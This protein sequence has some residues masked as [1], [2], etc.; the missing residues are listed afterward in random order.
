MSR[1]HNKFTKSILLNEMNYWSQ[2]VKDAS[3]DLGKMRHEKVIF[4][5]DF[6]FLFPYVWNQAPSPGVP[7]WYPTGRKTMENIIDLEGILQKTPNFDI[8]F[9][10]PSFLELLDSIRHQKNEITGFRFNNDLEKQFQ[11]V[12]QETSEDI[13]MDQLKKVLVSKGLPPRLLNF[14]WRTKTMD[15]DLD[16]AFDRIKSVFS[17]HKVLNGIGD[18]VNI[19]EIER[20][21][22]QFKEDY[23]KLFEVMYQSRGSHDTRDEPDKKLHYGVDVSNILTT[24]FLDKHVEGISMRF[25]T[26]NKLR[27]EFCQ[28]EGRNPN[29]LLLP[30]ISRR[31]EEGNEILD[32]FDYLQ[33]LSYNVKSIIRDLERLEDVC[34]ISDDTVTKLEKHFFKDVSSLIMNKNEEEDMLNEKRLYTLKQAFKG[35]GAVEHAI[36]ESETSLDDISNYLTGINPELLSKDPLI[37]VMESHSEQK[38][39]SEIRNNLAI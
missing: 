31:K 25:V 19:H 22:D 36:N 16:A 13:G 7:R 23:N 21:S 15:N 4:N 11:N 29:A 32:A 28:N 17:T 8:V 27:N 1:K 37:G 26:Q 12:M 30:L 9:S 14:L 35:E 2:V 24:I 10:G 34:N 33:D 20:W 5:L 6:T 38:V 3:N 39:I 18:H